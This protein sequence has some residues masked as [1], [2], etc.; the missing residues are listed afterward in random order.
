[1]KWQYIFELPL[2]LYYGDDCL[3]FPER[4]VC[5][6]NEMPPAYDLSYMNVTLNQPIHAISFIEDSCQRPAQ[7]HLARIQQPTNFNYF[8]FRPYADSS[9][10][11]FIV[12]DTWMDVDHP[13]IKGRADRW[14]SFVD[15]DPQAFPE[16][17]THCAGLIGGKTYGTARQSRIHSVHILDDDGQGDYG[18]M[19]EALHY[20][21][22]IAKRDEGKRKYI[23][24]MSLGGPQ[25]DAVNRAV[26]VVHSIAPV[27]VAAGNSN[28]DACGESPASAKVLTVA[29]SGPLNRFSDFS[30]FGSCVSLISPGESILSACPNNKTCWMSG[31]S[32]A[33]PLAAGVLGHYWLD[34]PELTV[35]QLAVHFLHSI[36]QGPVQGVPKNTPNKFVFKQ[37]PYC[38]FIVSDLIKFQI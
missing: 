23:V 6:G 11:E 13:E 1:M 32:M 33:T 5:F 22:T 8:N 17:A 15:H 7:W 38:S 34:K 3:R 2:G 24:S 10:V 14:K 37:A 12:M 29:A 35:S 18:S 4:V 19:I 9:R 27:V 16:H 21:F 28:R 31:T 26:E 25:S 30:N 36:S 20:V